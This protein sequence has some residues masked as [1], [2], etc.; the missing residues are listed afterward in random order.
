MEKGK[1]KTA[2]YYDKLKRTNPQKYKD[3]RIAQQTKYNKHGSSKSGT[4][5]I[6]GNDISRNAVKLNRHLGTYGKNDGKDASHNCHGPGKHCSE[7]E[8]INRARPRKKKNKSKL[9][10]T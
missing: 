5:D 9:Y 1:G 10:I 6:T 2:R 7:D 4:K 3:T 8:S